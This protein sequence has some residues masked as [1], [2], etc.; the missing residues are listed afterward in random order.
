MTKLAMLCCLK[1]NRRCTGAACLSTL[2]DRTRSF[3]PYEGQEV[4]LTAFARCNGCEAGIDEG[5]QEKLDRLV[6]EGTQVVHLGKCTDRKDTGPCPVIAQA[7]D[8]LAAKGI[9]IVHGTHRP[10]ICDI[11][12]AAER[13]S[14]NQIRPAVFPISRG[15]GRKR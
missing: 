12:N 13:I 8:Y 5:F 15:E 10:E 2:N 4:T 14:V 1:S 9:R 7:A 6:E 11:Q 3:A